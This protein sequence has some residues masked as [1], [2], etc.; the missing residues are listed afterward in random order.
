MSAGSRHGE[1]ANPK[2]QELPS[3]ASNDLDENDPGMWFVKDAERF[4][5]RKRRW[6]VL[7][8]ATRELAYYKSAFIPPA[9]AKR[10]GS[11]RL[12]DITGISSA[13]PVLEISVAKGRNMFRLVAESEAES[14]KWA[15][16]IKMETQTRLH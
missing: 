16:L 3:D 13:G 11:V 7:H 9:K 10:A 14:A 5:R 2:A 12:D 4:G 1:D 6:F 15:Y 8:R